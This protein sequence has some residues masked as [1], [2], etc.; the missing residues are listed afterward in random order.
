MKKM[1]ISL[2]VLVA[3]FVASVANVTLAA[4][5]IE[6]KKTRET[7]RFSEWTVRFSIVPERADVEQIVDLLRGYLK[8]EHSQIASVSFEDPAGKTAKI[9]F[10]LEKG[11]SASK[12]EK[13][14]WITSVGALCLFEVKFDSDVAYSRPT[15]KLTI[16]LAKKQLDVK[17][18]KEIHSVVIIEKK[19]GKLHYTVE[20]RGGHFDFVKGL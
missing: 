12:L 9:R 7:A 17:E 8:A 18:D 11:S 19:E 13:I 15:E 1:T 5:P 16:E 2:L 4:Q 14:T 3:L 20:F 6:I 10:T